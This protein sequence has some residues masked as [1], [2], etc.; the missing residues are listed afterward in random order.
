M[1]PALFDRLTRQRS[2]KIYIFPTRAGWGFV[3]LLSLLL[4]LSINFEN[5]LAY[6]LTFLLAALM[7]IALLFTHANL[8]GV[9]IKQVSTQPC[10]AGEQAGFSLMLSTTRRGEHQQLHVGWVGCDADY[11]I[12]LAESGPVQVELALSTR[13]RGWCVPPR[14]KIQTVFPLGLF[15]SWCYQP[16]TA[17]ALVYPQPLTT[18]TLPATAGSGSQGVLT[19]Q[20]GSDDFTELKPFQAGESPQHIAWKVFARGQGLHTKRFGARQDLD[21]WLDYDAWPQAS[22]ELRLSYLCGWV[23]KLDR[24]QRLY[25]VRLPDQT[26]PPAQGEAHRRSILQALALFGRE[27]SRGDD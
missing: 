11:A 22:Q 14:V 17:R 9:T 5:N 12:D 7:L 3:L 26:W 6:A 21:L 24:E 15:K 4:L 1:K 13:Q 27:A 25:G 19:Q 16:L 2:G 20:I 10:F 23:L 18:Q 8:A